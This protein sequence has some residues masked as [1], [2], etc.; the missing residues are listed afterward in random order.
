VGRI[1]G[2]EVTTMV[3]LT[4]AHAEALALVGTG[5]LTF[6]QVESVL[7]VFSAV[8]HNTSGY[9]FYLTGTLDEA[10]VSYHAFVDDK[11]I[12]LSTTIGQD[13]S[14]IESIVRGFL[15]G[16]ITEVFDI[17]LEVGQNDYDYTL[18]F[19]SKDSNIW[20]AFHFRLSRTPYEV[21]D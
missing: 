20:G 21:I 2:E 3:K 17:K 14:S 7:D 11:C 6:E 5:A 18:A 12:T 15:W 13:Q 1:T 10:S 16:G 4:D 19:T 9:R 8:S